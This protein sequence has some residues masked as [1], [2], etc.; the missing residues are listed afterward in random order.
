MTHEVPFVEKKDVSLVVIDSSLEATAIRDVLEAFNYR[1]TTHWVGSR[2]ELIEILSGNI[3]TSNTVILS[4]HGIEEGIYTPD[5]DPLTTEEIARTAKLAGKT[6]VN[7]GCLTGKSTYQEAFT[8][9]GVTN[10]IG[11]SDYPSGNA[12]LLYVITLFYGLSV[13][14]SLADAHGHARTTSEDGEQFVLN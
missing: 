1:V 3:E 10:Y 11:P 8:N 5:E 13:G 14:E 4:C 7:L 12:T 2:K 6:V 9:A